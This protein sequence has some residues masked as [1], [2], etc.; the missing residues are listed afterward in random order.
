MEIKKLSVCHFDQLL[1]LLNN[2]FGRKYG[3]KMDFEREQPKV[4]VRDEEHMQRH[5]GVFDGEKLC[6]VIGIYPLHINIG[7]EKCVFYTT[8]NIATAPECEGKGYM[9]FLLNETMNELERINADAARLGGDRARYGRYG[10]EG[11]GIVY[12]FQLSENNRK[13]LFSDCNSDLTFEKI[14]RTD[15]E[16]LK[17]C[18]ELNHQRRVYVDRSTEDGLRDVFLAMCSKSCTPYIALSDGKPV[19]YVS[20]TDD[21]KN[22]YEFAA[23]D[24]NS[25]QDMLCSWQK[26]CGQAIFFSLPPFMPKEIS[27]F[28]DKCEEYSIRFPSRFKIIN[29]QKVVNAFMKLKAEYDTLPDGELVLGIEG[30]GNIRLFVENANAGCEKTDREAE[31]ILSAAKATQL[32]FGPVNPA[33]VGDT[34][35]FARALFPLPLSWDTLDYC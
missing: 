28:I 15:T 35:V 24:L 8:G 19:G 33:I 11:S 25:M 13:K 26:H 17:F 27:L 16:L 9:T 10:Y 22:I 4:W 6:A 1:N 2:V 20:V 32:L 30:Y 14:N 21:I 12:H 31:V 7:T 18:L 5:L 23:I 29:W 34:P 3:R